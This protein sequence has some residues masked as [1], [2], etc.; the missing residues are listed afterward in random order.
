VV[1]EPLADT[2]DRCERVIAGEQHARRVEDLSRLAPREREALY[3]SVLGSRRDERRLT[4]ASDTAASR[5]PGE[6]RTRP[7][8]RP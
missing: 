6:R 7:H 8:V 5:R 1:P 3:L 2:I 4:D